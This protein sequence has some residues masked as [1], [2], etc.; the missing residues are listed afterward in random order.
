MTNMATTNNPGE[1]IV[2]AMSDGSVA[3]V[4]AV[5]AG[6]ERAYR[7]STMLIE[8]AERG[9]R[10]MLE[11]VRRFAQDPTGLAGLTG[12]VVDK[13]TAAQSRAFELG[14][15]WFEE[16]SDANKEMRDTLQRI[17]Q[18]NREAGQATVEGVRGLLSRT[19]APVNPFARQTKQ[20]SQLPGDGKA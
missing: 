14:R 11:V 3:V 6:N 12:T 2:S 15:H 16:L 20:A 10:E 8:E 4:E 1:R 9:Q 19:D 7:V 13:A 18:A 5:K 17:V